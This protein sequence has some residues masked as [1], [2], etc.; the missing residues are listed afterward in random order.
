MKPESYTTKKNERKT[1]L[2]TRTQMSL[3][4]E[5]MRRRFVY[6]RKSEL[7]DKMIR[8]TKMSHGD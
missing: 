8:I 2:T 7:T 3:L 5:R 6:S 4:F 1:E